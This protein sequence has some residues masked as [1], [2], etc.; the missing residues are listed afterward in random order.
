VARRADP[1]RIYQAGRAAIRN[2]LLSSGITDET[3]ER[4][5]QSWEIEAA[6]RGIPTTG[7][8]W[9][10]GDAWIEEQRAERHRPS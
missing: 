8:F 10:V 3:A 5:L 1:A 9:T 2:R 4:W 7:D 6:T